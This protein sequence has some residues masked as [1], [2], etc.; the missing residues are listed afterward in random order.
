MKSEDR[1]QKTE[2]RKQRTENREQKIK[3]CLLSSVFCLLSIG[4]AA[5]VTRPLPEI[6]A[7]KVSY[8]EGSLWP[9]EESKLLLFKDTKA[10]KVGDIVT[11]VIAESSQA[12]KASETKT[13]RASD[14]T[15]GFKAGTGI[16]TDFQ[17]KGGNKFEGIGTTTR[18]GNLNATVTAVVVEVLPNGN[19]KIDGVKDIKVNDETQYM[20]VSG[21]VRPED[22]SRNNSVISTDIA[23]AKILYKGEGSLDDE[24]RPGWLGKAFKWIWPF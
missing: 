14:N 10:N 4:C 9:K 11:V 16:P 5:K 15:L 2:N 13:S 18:A 24:Q 1:R 23:D 21:I 17:V 22:I 19:L 12:S 3:V 7:P 8:E 20:T 6:N